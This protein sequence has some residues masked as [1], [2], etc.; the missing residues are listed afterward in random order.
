MLLQPKHRHTK[1]VQGDPHSPKELI[2][3]EMGW[4]E[5]KPLSPCHGPQPAFPHQPQLKPQQHLE[6][7]HEKHNDYDGTKESRP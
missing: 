1:L 4:Q 3:S 6:P 5:G 2:A 7:F